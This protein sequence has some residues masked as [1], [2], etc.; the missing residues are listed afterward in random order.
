[1]TCGSVSVNEEG[2]KTHGNNYPMRMLQR[3]GEND[4]SLSLQGEYCAHRRI[5]KIDLEAGRKLGLGC[6]SILWAQQS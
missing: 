6:N 5:Q 1:M 4:R 2:D 3:H